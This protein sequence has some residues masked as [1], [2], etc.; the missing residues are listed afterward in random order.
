[1]KDKSE[2]KILQEMLDEQCRINGMGAQRELKLLTRIDE[3]EKSNDDAANQVVALDEIIGEQEALI[4]KLVEALESAKAAI[5]GR[6]HTGF[7]D[8]ALSSLPERFKL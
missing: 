7:I 3:L 2:A 4:R 1:M 5:K 6:E 8:K